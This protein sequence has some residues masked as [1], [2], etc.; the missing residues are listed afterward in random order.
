MATYDTSRYDELY[1]DFEKKQR[2]T[3][4]KQKTQTE[5]DF[6]QRLKEAYISNMQ[7]KKS[8]GEAM[9]K[10]GIRGGA[11]ETAML[12]TNIGYQNTR[13]QLG[14]EKAQAIQD[15]EDNANANIFD[16]KQANDAAKI[17]Y[18]EQREAE[19]RQIA[20]N[21]VAV[22]QAAEQDYLAAKYGDVYNI[23]TLNNALA[24]AKTKQEQAIIKAR[25]N[26]L[27]AYSKGY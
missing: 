22:E 16:Y 6:N 7:D 12:K 11:T 15:I 9:T 20:Q 14:R 26:Y 19:D 13:N 18:I 27:T 10:A 2:E 5:S 8:L 24:N 3:A 1:K 17:S 23:T 4:E 21:A 25:I